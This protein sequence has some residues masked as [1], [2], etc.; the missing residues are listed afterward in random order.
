MRDITMPVWQFVRLMV[1]IEE[2]QDKYGDVNLRK[3]YSDG[4]T[5]GLILMRA[6]LML[7]T[8]AARN[9]PT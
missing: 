1:K 8:V 3:L 2:T 4:K 9:L 6:Y 5:F 7:A